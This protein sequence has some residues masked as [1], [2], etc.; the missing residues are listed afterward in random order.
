MNIR[1]DKLVL[2]NGSVV[3]NIWFLIIILVLVYSSQL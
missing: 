3:T 1:A 2:A